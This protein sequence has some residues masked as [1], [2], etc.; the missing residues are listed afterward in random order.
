MH[1]K[2]EPFFRGCRVAVYRLSVA[3]AVKRLIAGGY[4]IRMS[5]Y[6]LRM[7]VSTV[8]NYYT[9]AQREGLAG[10]IP[11]RRGKPSMTRLQT[12]A[13]TKPPSAPKKS[14]LPPRE[15]RRIDSK[16]SLK[17]TL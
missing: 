11:K 1:T 8:W 17:P 4:S 7:P 16:T 13:A 3:D 15:A 2:P 6:E 14:N 5:A 9:R 10:V 12:F